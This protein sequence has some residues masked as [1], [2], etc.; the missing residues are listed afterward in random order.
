MP[1]YKKEKTENTP[2][3]NSSLPIPPI[4]EEFK[5]LAFNETRIVCDKPMSKR[6]KIM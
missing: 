4:A 6:I 2:S 1:R 3:I 5:I